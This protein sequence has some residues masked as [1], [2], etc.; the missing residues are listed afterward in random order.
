[1]PSKKDFIIRFTLNTIFVTMFLLFVGISIIM[2]VD[3]S[4]SV[5]LYIQWLNNSLFLLAIYKHIVHRDTYLKIIDRII[6]PIAGFMSIWGLYHYFTGNSVCIGGSNEYRALAMFDNPNSLAG[7][8][9][10]IFIILS[11]RYL[12]DIVRK[13]K[14]IFFTLLMLISAGFIATQSRAGLISLL[15]GICVYL[16]FV[17]WR[18][19]QKRWVHLM[20]IIVGFNGIFYS[21]A[22]FSSTVVGR[23]RSIVGTNYLP[24]GL[25]GRIDLWI[26]ALQIAKDHP[27]F[28]TGIGT[29]YLMLPSKSSIDRSFVESMA[30]SDYLQFLSEI[31]FVGTISFII[32]LMVYLWIGFKLVKTFK[33]TEEYLS[34]QENMVISI[35]AASIIPIVHSFVDY[36]LRTP[37]VFALFLFLA[38]FIWH[39]A[40]KAGLISG[41][42]IEIKNSKAVRNAIK[43]VGFLVAIVVVTF[44]S[45][46]VVSDYYYRK[47]LKSERNENY[48]S[49]IEY[50][51]KAISL[52]STISNYHN[53]RARNYYRLGLLM[54]DSSSRNTVLRESEREFLVA[55]N[56]SAMVT[57]NYIGLAS[58]Y[59]TNGELF[60]SSS[61]KI[62]LLYDEAR[63]LS[64]S[65]NIYR[66]NFAEILLKAGIYDRA[67]ESLEDTIGRGPQLKNSLTLLAEAYRLSGDTE[68]AGVTI[69]KKIIEDP[70]DGFANFVKGNVL[71]DLEK[72]DEAIIYYLKALEK[73]RGDNR[74]DVLKRLALT[75][76][77]N[78][79]AERATEYLNK[80]LNE[81]PYD[82][83]SLG[84][85]EKD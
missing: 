3:K 22:K 52:R 32:A 70:I 81:R 77:D 30:H 74:I 76:W 11:A 5:W 29:F 47:A 50:A 53:F 33:R 61:Q 71:I 78:G 68:K 8:L 2:S 85:I 59:E 44:I 46:T 1:M 35:Y 39:E 10:M 56:L 40:Q 28:G 54:T 17:G 43:L 9:G 6:F 41:Y 45:L 73:S 36:D 51:N 34:A 19:N 26:S 80:I 24:D 84:A 82:K 65:N 67:I 63:V 72:S 14:I 31:G 18:T 64:P 49:G 75:Y 69:D 13:N 7:Y 83:F 16:I 60:D 21:L 48:L 58:L 38:S 66:Y 23:I 15:I 62:A 12:N 20:L 79:D 42:S 25:D 57:H 37:G 55:I 4:T 27:F